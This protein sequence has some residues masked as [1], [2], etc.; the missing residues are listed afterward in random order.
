MYPSV[1][2]QINGV[3]RVLKDIIRP[4]LSSAYERDVLHWSVRVLNLVAEEA[5]MAHPLHV[6]EAEAIVRLFERILP[7]LDRYA[8]EGGMAVAMVERVR[9]A[10][11]DRP[12][13]LTD[14]AA[15]EARVNRLRDIA[16]ELARTI[17]FRDGG[18]TATKAFQNYVCELAEMNVKAFGLKTYA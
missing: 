1:V 8:A 4:A 17:T 15:A 13:D 14:V 7:D 10:I 9:S 2:D 18:D 5:V 11:G 12:A 16:A 6:R 3:K